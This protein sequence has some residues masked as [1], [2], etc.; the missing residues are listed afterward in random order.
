M[1]TAD[2]LAGLAAAATTAGASILA[3]DRL[4]FV[5]VADHIAAAGQPAPADPPTAA[6]LAAAATLREAADIPTVFV[7]RA[8]FLALLEAARAA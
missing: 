7:E 1:L 3:I 4:T 2:Q 6:F 8:H 5:A